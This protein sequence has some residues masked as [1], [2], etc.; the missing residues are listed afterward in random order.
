MSVNKACTEEHSTAQRRK[1]LSKKARRE[2][3]PAGSDVTSNACRACDI[4]VSQARR[5]EVPAGSDVILFRVMSTMIQT[6]FCFG[7]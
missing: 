6:S 4:I 5:E 1:C 2:E 3:M 7:S